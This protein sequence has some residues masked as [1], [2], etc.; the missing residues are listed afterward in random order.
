MAYKGF[1]Y[2]NLL[3]CPIHSRCSVNTKMLMR[4]YSVSIVKKW[5]L[6]PT[7][8]AL[9]SYKKGHPSRKGAGDGVSGVGWE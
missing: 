8:G 5:S 2:F 9:S 3:P 6:K 1:S 4:I 7:G